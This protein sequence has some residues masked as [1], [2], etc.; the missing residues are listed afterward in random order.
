MDDVIDIEEKTRDQLKQREQARTAELRDT[1]EK[2]KREIAE[3]KRIEAELTAGERRYRTLVETA[4]DIIWTVDLNLRFTYLSPSITQVLGFTEGEMLHTC[5][6][7]GLSP[8]ARREL[9]AAFDVE[10]AQETPIPRDHHVSRVFEVGWYHK[11]GSLKC[12]ETSMR[13]LR[14]SRNHPIGILGISRDITD[15][16]NAEEALRLERE[17]FRLLLEHA[18]IAMVMIQADGTY[19]YINPK[20]KEVFGYDL[21]DVPNGRE[22]FRKAFPDPEVRHRIISTWIDTV[23][24]SKPGELT[25]RTCQVVCNDGNKRVVHFKPVRLETGEYLVTCE[26]CTDRILAEDAL[27]S[28][29][30]RYRT[31]YE[32][33]KKGKE[34]YRS[35]IDS[36]ADAI[37]IYDLHGKVIHVSPSFTQMFGW[38]LNEIK[39]RRVPYVPD[40]EREVSMLLIEQVIR[41]GVPVSGLETKRYTRDGR[42]LELSVMASRYNDHQGTPSGMLVILSDI[43]DRKRAERALQESEERYR[44]LNAEL[45]QRVLERTGQLQAANEELEA[46]C[47]SVSHDLRAPLR[48][49]DGFS[50]VLLEDYLA[51]LDTAGQDCLRRVRAASQRMAL[52]IDDL[53]KLSRVTRSDMKSDKVDLSELART[54]AKDLLESENSRKIEFAIT[55]GLVVNGDR[56]LLKVALENLMGNAW[57]FTRDRELARVEFGVV[58]G[59]SSRKDGGCSKP[60]YLVRDNGAGFDMKYSAKLFGP[61]QRLHREDEFPGS[62]IGLATVQRII[63]RHGGSIWGESEVDRGATFYFTL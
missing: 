51:N 54:I 8:D 40:S 26:D 5:A 36:S 52:L 13:F 25:S 43:S 34:L 28:S 55:P 42:V 27:R 58:Q 33:S 19:N 20:F 49:I 7:D 2:L 4:N 57:K 59:A 16:R 45:E 14:D 46:F 60:V 37:V 17:K 9:L 29:E 38:T 23:E 32:K 48:S 50:Q 11:D 31:L 24:K 61:F 39:G 18:P 3:R 44:K 53:L 30:E 56:R 41:T 62:G 6:M 12:L 63:H 47:Y 10:I 35:L 22:W 15:R 1:N 21:N